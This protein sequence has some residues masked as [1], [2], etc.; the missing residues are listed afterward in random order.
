MHNLFTLL[1]N[2]QDRREVGVQSKTIELGES[3]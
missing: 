2:E 3:D 1:D